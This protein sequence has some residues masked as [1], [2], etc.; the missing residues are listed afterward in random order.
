MCVHE[1]YN[2]PQAMPLRVMRSFDPVPYEE[3][4]RNEL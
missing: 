4:S 3:P 1:E 2:P